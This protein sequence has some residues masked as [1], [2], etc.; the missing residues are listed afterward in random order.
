MVSIEGYTITEMLIS[1]IGSFILIF[2]F[3][4][5][6]IVEDWKR[7]RPVQKSILYGALLTLFSI[8]GLLLPI[9]IGLFMIFD[10][11]LIGLIIA[12]ISNLIQYVRYEK[13]YSAELRLK[14]QQY[15]QQQQQQY[16]RPDWMQ[17]DNGIKNKNN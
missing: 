17:V 7:R 13:Q 9:R 12:V 8:A 16:S 5:L 15:A 1:I 11:V 14:Q 10:G 4:S 6:R 2:L 3:S